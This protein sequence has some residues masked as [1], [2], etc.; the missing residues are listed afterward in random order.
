VSAAPDGRRAFRLVATLT[1]AGLC[2]GLAIVVAHRATLPRIEANQAAAL[3]AA[4]FEVLPGA[5]AMEKRVW[6]GDGLARDGA[7]AEA[8]YAAFAADGRLLGYAI[9]GEGA[10]FQDTIR[11]L[12]GFDPARRRIV[13][14]RVLESRETPGLGDK[15]YKDPAFVGEFA[16]LAVEPAVEAVKGRGTAAHQVDAI[17]GATISSKAVVRIVAGANAVWLPRLPA[18]DGEDGG[19]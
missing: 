12:Y 19:V 6:T 17:T 11:L 1:G 4:V 7:G 2:C 16:D 13:G 8:V 18:G 10:G 3:T 15:I 14:M 5:V 9:P